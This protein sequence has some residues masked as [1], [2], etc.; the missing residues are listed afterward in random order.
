MNSLNDLQEFAMMVLTL[1][2][3]VVATYAVAMD[4]AS[5][6]GLTP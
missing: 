6:S 5:M 1:A 3:G 4:F 2:L